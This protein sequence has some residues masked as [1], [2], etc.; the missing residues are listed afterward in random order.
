M[1]LLLELFSG[2]GSVGKV[3]KEMGF[4]VVSL[5]LQNADINCDIMKWDYTQYPVKHFDMI[6]ASPPCTEYSQAKK[7]GIR[8]IAEANEIVLKTIE[9]IKYFQPTVFI[10][11]NPQTG[12]L[13]SQPLW[14]SFH[15]LMWIIVCM[16]LTTESELVCGI[17]LFILHPRNV[18][19]TVER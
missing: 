11:E 7:T 1:K 17:T 10:I 6:W 5:D 19:K 3:A 4:K 8:K 14:M 9:I 18:I 16:V 13:K 12:L 15:M 2:T